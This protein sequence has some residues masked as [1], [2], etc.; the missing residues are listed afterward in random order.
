MNRK[1][2]GQ[3]LIGGVFTACALVIT[4]LLELVTKESEETRED[5]EPPAER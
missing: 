3:L 4:A 1:R 5:P 2:L